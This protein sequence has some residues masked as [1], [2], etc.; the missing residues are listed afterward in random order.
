M[1]VGEALT[2]YCRNIQVRC[3]PDSSPQYSCTLT[4]LVLNISTGLQNSGAQ[5][6]VQNYSE[7]RVP[8]IQKTI[9]FI[10]TFWVNRKQWWSGS[11][12]VSLMKSGHNRWERRC[13]TSAILHHTEKWKIYCVPCVSL[14]KFHCNR[15]IAL[16]CYK[17]FFFFGTEDWSQNT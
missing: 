3:L 9:L 2:I 11:F 16:W 10:N 12:S 7:P 17:T 1:V 14:F 6:G 4:S 15:W 8:K 13:K 5:L